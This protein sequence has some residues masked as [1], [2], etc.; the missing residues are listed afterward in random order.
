M[1]IPNTVKPCQLDGMLEQQQS[2][3]QPCHVG[4]QYF[5]DCVPVHVPRLTSL[6]P[7]SSSASYQPYHLSLYSPLPNHF[8]VLPISSSL[9]ILLDSALV[10]CLPYKKKAKVHKHFFLMIAAALGPSSPLESILLYNSN[11]SLSSVSPD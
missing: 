11:E 9:F 2:I 5:P 1:V 6:H 8:N 10:R 4:M 3:K 7:T